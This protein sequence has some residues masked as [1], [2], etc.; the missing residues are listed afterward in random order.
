MIFCCFYSKFQRHHTWAYEVLWL[1][2]WI[3]H[4][5]RLKKLLIFV[6]CA[7]SDPTFLLHLRFKI[8]TIFLLFSRIV[9]NKAAERAKGG[10]SGPGS[11]S[12]CGASS[13]V[14]QTISAASVGMTQ[15]SM[16][17]DNRPS[18]SINGILGIPQQDANANI[19]KRKRE[20]EGKTKLEHLLHRKKLNEG[21]TKLQRWLHRIINVF[22]Y[23]SRCYPLWS[24]FPWQANKV[25]HFSIDGQSML[26]LSPLCWQSNHA[27][28]GKLW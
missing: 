28:T 18:Y 2:N 24:S 4:F 7:D 12:V 19:N 10:S 21:K 6:C 1:R 15:S 23:M 5:W 8:F 11:N 3:I 26:E 14:S 27:S 22:P 17:L 13:P 25:E 16:V 9:R 20:D